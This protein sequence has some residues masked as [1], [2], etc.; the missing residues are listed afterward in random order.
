LGIL[1]ARFGLTDKAQ[2][3][4]Q[5]AAQGGDYAPA[6]VNLGNLLFLKK[7]WQNAFDYYDQ[8]RKI[9]PALQG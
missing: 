1:Y 5:E 9:D 4:F 7:D 3:Q 2:V 8:A 6:L